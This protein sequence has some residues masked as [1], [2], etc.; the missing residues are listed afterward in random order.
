MCS[1]T[2]HFARLNGDKLSIQQI[3]SLRKVITAKYNHRISFTDFTFSRGF[4][5]RSLFN[6]TNI[7]QKPSQHIVKAF[8]HG[9]ISFP[10]FLNN[11]LAKIDNL[12]YLEI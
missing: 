7:I 6:N 9:S 1:E 2:Q 10:N 11:H 8:V 5:I 3:D 12:K 4:V